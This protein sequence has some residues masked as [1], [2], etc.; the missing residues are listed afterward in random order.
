MKA[1]GFVVL[2]ARSNVLAWSHVVKLPGCSGRDPV[3]KAHDCRLSALSCSYITNEQAL[4]DCFL[5]SHSHYAARF[6]LAL[7]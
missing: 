4:S 7:P 5:S 2:S 3:A 1:T 6:S